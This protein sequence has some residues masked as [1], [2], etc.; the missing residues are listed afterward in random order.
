MQKGHFQCNCP[1]PKRK[2]EKLTKHNAKPAKESATVDSDTDES[3]FTASS[4]QSPSEQWL[5]DSGATSHM[6]YSREL[7]HRYCKFNEP[8]MVSLG[9]GRTVEAIGAGDIELNMMFKVSKKKRCT[10]KK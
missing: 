6:T 2:E 9:D 8:Q 5:I 3:Y 7:L 4:N 10:M 1:R